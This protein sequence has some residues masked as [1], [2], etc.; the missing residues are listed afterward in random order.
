MMLFGPQVR[1]ARG[2]LGW[3]QMQLSHSAGVGLST[4]RRMEAEKG[5]VSGYIDNAIRIRNA[6]EKAGVE[7]ID[8]DERG[9]GVRIQKPL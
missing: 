2:L 4:V 9:P 7:F 6:L 3:S 5:V 8:Q 1:A